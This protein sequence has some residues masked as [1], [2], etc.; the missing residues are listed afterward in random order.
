MQSDDRELESVDPTGANI[1]L[2]V[3]N[4]M[5][6][7]KKFRDPEISTEH[8]ETGAH[9]L[10]SDGS[11]KGESPRKPSNSRL[12]KDAVG[13]CQQRNTCIKKAFGKGSGRH[14]SEA[15]RVAQDTAK[16]GSQ[17]LLHERRD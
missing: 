10:Y 2:L 16:V 14:N 15:Q 9:E 7:T 17:T 12:F 13:E 3:L 11:P 1:V 6:A 8:E 4:L 5:Q